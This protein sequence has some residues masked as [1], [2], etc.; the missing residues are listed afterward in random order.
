MGHKKGPLITLQPGVYKY[1][2]ECKLPHYLPSSLSAGFGEISYCVESNIDLENRYKI[3]FGETPFT[4]V[5]YDDL[6]LYPELRSPIRLETV[7]SFCFI[8]CTG[9][10]IVTVS[11]P[12]TGFALGQSVPIKIEYLN[13]SSVN[14]KHTKVILKRA[15]RFTIHHPKTQTK[16]FDDIIASIISDGVKA[17][18]SKYLET[19][20]EIPQN[21]ICS[22]DRFCKIITVTYSIDIEGEL[23]AL[24]SNPKIHIPVTIGNVLISSPAIS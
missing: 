21:L 20:L 8:L 1:S 14:V 4:I 13:K 7:K 9:S 2:F 10:L 11:M 5:R 17:R 3:C 16:T 19:I 15:K 6:N 24:H 23:A 18:Q 22:N 12:C